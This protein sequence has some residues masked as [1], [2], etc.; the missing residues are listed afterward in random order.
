MLVIEPYQSRVLKN[1]L[2]N[3]LENTIIGI[4][5]DEN[6]HQNYNVYRQQDIE[7]LVYYLTNH[8]SGIKNYIAGSC[9]YQNL[10][11]VVDHG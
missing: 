9:Y 11:Q 8:I 5:S 7:D 10:K 3:D 4:K 6:L 1:N 2:A